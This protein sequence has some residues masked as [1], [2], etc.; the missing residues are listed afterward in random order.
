MREESER[1]YRAL[2]CVTCTV[3]MAVRREG[4][5]EIARCERCG[6]TVLQ[7]FALLGLLCSELGGAER[8]LLAAELEA[9]GGE[10]IAGCPQCGRAGVRFGELHEVWIGRCADCRTV[11][12]PSGALDEL[13]WR[14]RDGKLT[15]LIEE[16]EERAEERRR[17]FGDPADP[18]LAGLAADLVRGWRA[19][20]RRLWLRRRRHSGLPSAPA[21]PR[22][23]GDAP[24]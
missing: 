5:F 12:L 19:L 18:A 15:E 24:V 7:D 17:P 8:L 21:R 14:L 11:T 9:V 4:D 23:G 1:V 16:L 22:G 2:P 20:S 3:P 10:E 6:A 13:R